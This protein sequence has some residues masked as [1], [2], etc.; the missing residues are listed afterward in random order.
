MA[1]TRTPDRIRPTGRGVLTLSDP[2]RAA[3]KGIMT[4]GFCQVTIVDKDLKH[5]DENFK[6][7]NCLNN[8]AA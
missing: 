4:L 7:F 5:K 6:R 2:R 1:L 8:N 3:K